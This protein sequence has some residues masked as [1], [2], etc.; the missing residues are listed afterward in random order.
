MYDREKVILTINL[1]GSLK[2]L[3]RITKEYKANGKRRRKHLKV[4]EP[5]KQVINLSHEFIE[6]A[7]SMEGRPHIKADFSTF[8]H[9]KKMNKK[10]RL[11]YNIRILV[12]DIT[13]IHK[14]ILEKDYTWKFV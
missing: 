4:H 11:G 8:A 5:A 2:N 13:S 10:A 12:S 14:P 1:E 3:S 7:S 9:W 6:H